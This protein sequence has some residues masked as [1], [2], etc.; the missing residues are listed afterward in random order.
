MTVPRRILIVEDEPLIAMMLEDFIESLG[1]EV[2]G[3][4]ESVTEA[5]AMVEADGFDLAILDVHARHA[6]AGGGE[7]EVVVEA[8]RLGPRSDPAVPVDGAVAE[9]KVPLA[10]DT[11]RVA[12]ALEDRRER[13][14]ARLAGR[15][16]LRSARA[17]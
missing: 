12:G 15:C 1:H 13:R 2:R 5:L 8:N 3:P 17:G 14:A 16:P 6:V 10:D 4:C 7:D 11:G 9:A